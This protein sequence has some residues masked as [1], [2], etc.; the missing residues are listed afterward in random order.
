VAALTPL[1]RDALREL[2]RRGVG[3]KEGEALPW[4]ATYL[5]EHNPNK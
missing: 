4:L 2:M 1:L 3:A 5:K